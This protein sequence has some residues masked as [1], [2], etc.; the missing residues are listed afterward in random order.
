MYFQAGNYI[1]KVN[2][3]TIEILEQGKRY[4]QS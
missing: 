4:V 1:F 2:K 3:L